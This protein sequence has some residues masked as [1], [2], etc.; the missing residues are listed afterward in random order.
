M[1]ADPTRDPARERAVSPHETREFT[2]AVEYTIQLTFVVAGGAR[3][4]TAHARARRL[5]E[6]LANTAARAKGVVDVRA[7]AGASHDGQLLAP[8]RVCF[9]AANSGHGTGADPSKL[10]RYLDPDHERALASLAEA[11]A[12][13]W[14]RRQADFDR[15]CA[16]GCSNPAGLGPGLARPCRCAYCRPQEHLELRTETPDPWADGGRCLC[17]RASTPPA[18][19][20]RPHRGQQLVVLDGDPPELTRLAARIAR[21]HASDRTQPPSGVTTRVCHRLAADPALNRSAHHPEGDAMPAPPPIRLDID[22]D[23]LPAVTF[24]LQRTIDDL[25]ARAIVAADRDPDLGPSSA[26]EY[27]T[28]IG[29]LAGLL[30]QL[31]HTTARPDP[32]RAALVWHDGTYTIDSGRPLRLV[33]TTALDRL[34]SQAAERR[35]DGRLTPGLL[36]DLLAET[37][38]SSVVEVADRLVAARRAART[39]DRHLDAQADRP[40]VRQISRELPGPETS[41]R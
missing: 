35:R 19:G 10:D 28:D 15:R 34:L 9:D 33:A 16:I 24:A 22:P 20:C 31:G 5:A 4:R 14:V 7:V 40:P 38:G 18:L 41:L 8:E 12:T 11:N 26:A 39:S 37:T 29:R 13:A 1:A 30:D 3:W 2:N 17:G 6:R 36:I 27:R 25:E 23:A 21:S 32:E